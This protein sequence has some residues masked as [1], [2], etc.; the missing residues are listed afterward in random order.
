MLTR[1]EIITRMLVTYLLYVFQPY[2]PDLSGYQQEEQEFLNRP[3]RRFR[4][5]FS[6]FRVFVVLYIYIS[7]LGQGLSIVATCLI[8]NCLVSF[9]DVRCVL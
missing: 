4:P 7:D 6:E 9:E 5:Y 8:R 1:I 3:V 2:S